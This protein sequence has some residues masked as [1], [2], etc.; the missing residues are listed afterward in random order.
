MA[1][2]IGTT[3]RNLES[4]ARWV[5]GASL[6]AGMLVC[7]KPGYRMWGALTMA[8]MLVWML[9]LIWRTVG[10][11]RSIPAHPVYLALIVPVLILVCHAA[12]AG[13]ASAKETRNFLGGE[14]NM[15]LIFHFW[16]LAMGVMLSQSLLP[17]AAR[18][19][20]VLSVCGAAMMIG[21]VLAVV[22]GGQSG[23]QPALG[24]VGLAGVCVWL[25]PLWPMGGQPLNRLLQIRAIRITYLA[26]AI[27]A[28]GLLAWFTPVAAAGA[29][30]VAAGVMGLSG[31]IFPAERKGL[32]L[33]AGGILAVLIPVLVSSKHLGSLGEVEILLLGRGEEVFATLSASDSGLAL[34]TG[35]VGILGVGWMILGMLASIVYLMI[36]TRRRQGLAQGR[37][38]VWAIAASLAACGLFARGGLAIP[39]V[40][41][42]VAFC[43]GL[44][45]SMLARPYLKRSGL[46]ILLAVVVMLMMLALL[47]RGGLPISIVSDMGG[48]DRVLHFVAGFL[49]AM[50]VGWM[51]GAKRLWLGLVGIAAAVAAG[52]VGEWVQGASGFRSVQ[53]SDFL[54]HMLGSLAALP[55]Y[56]LCIGSRLCESADASR[57]D[58]SGAGTRS[59]E[60]P[61]G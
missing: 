5:L 17:R 28:A 39:S 2:P 48:D 58:R 8:V 6:C 36:S 1:I 9:W 32:L 3:A 37:S 18:H 61:M 19:A 11:D 22:L 45:P 60:S 15:S 23:G 41:L 51:L 57:R 21:S 52:A 33:T 12:D 50:V 20:V 42:A 47:R 38:V 59:G 34:L 55:I 43:W 44:L 26:A 30:L 54:A 10:G 14:L 29:L 4:L 31:L 53:L 46:G 24:F 27:G 16:L 56:L 35:M 25:T 13:L 49:L 7:W 40:T